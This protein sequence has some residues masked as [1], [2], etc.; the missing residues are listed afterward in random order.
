MP[1]KEIS[2]K[3]LANIIQ[4][5]MSEIMDFVT[6]HLKQ[7]GLDNRMLNGGVVLTGGGSQLKHLI[8]L[9]E[10]VTGLNARIGF[11]TEHLAGGHIEEL[12]KPTYATCIGLILKGYSDYEHNRKQF[13][14]RFRK[15]EVPEALRKAA[16]V[17]T[18]ETFATAEETQIEK[19]KNRK[20]IKDFWGK[21][22]DGIID[23]F[24]EEEDHAL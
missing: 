6:Y 3:N 17:E 11:P 7:V 22:K 4:A 8:Q 9:T 13:E 19:V 18:E 2:V 5:R 14:H 15:V 12:A 10:Y 24:K 1:A 21:F 16:E 23:L 20:G